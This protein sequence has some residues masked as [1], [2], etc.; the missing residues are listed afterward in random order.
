MN[1]ASHYSQKA[2]EILHQSKI[3]HQ[4]RAKRLKKLI[5]QKKN[6]NPTVP[7]VPVSNP[8]NLIEN[9][10]PS[11]PDGE[12]V[13][14]SPSEKKFVEIKKEVINFMMQPSYRKTSELMNL[15]RLKI[16]Q[17]AP[18]KPSSTT[19][20]DDRK[21]LEEAAAAAQMEQMRQRGN[22][23]VLY[24]FFCLFLI[25]FLVE[26]ERIR[27]LEQLKQMNEMTA[28]TTWKCTVCSRLNY[29]KLVQC[30][31]CFTFRHPPSPPKK[32]APPQKTIIIPPG[33]VL[34]VRRDANG[35][36]FPMLVPQQD[37][38]PA[39]VA[40]S[41]IGGVIMNGNC[42][43]CN[44]KI[45]LQE[46]D[47]CHQCYEEYVSSG[48]VNELPQEQELEVD[49][50]RCEDCFTQYKTSTSPMK[51]LQCQ[52]T[53]FGVNYKKK[54]SWFKKLIPNIMGTGG[55]STPATTPL[56]ITDQNQNYYH[57]QI[58]QQQQQAAAA[59]SLPPPQATSHAVPPPPATNPH[60]TSDDDIR[61]QY[62]QQ[63]DYH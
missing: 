4:A 57:Q 30:P 21:V 31:D 8:P 63:Y 1:N 40:S 10:A 46:G 47:L 16:P 25:S 52:G 33:Y 26:A 18:I 53:R 55:S 36:Q 11:L 14:G 19:A 41:P 6:L 5:Q 50:Y 12:E 39:P 54:K 34:I 3:D 2:M 45:N 37:S 38:I 20:D 61:S 44:Q 24:C 42:R 58:Q 9:A 32:Q 60:Y 27:E 43:Q 48:K 22:L 17:V 62:Y 56:V 23:S 49:F 15:E 35:N 13:K 29:E 51:C 7:A 28:A 59:S